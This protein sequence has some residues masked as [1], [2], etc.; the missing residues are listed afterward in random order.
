MT[1]PVH[2]HEQGV[3]KQRVIRA[4]LATSISVATL[5]HSAINHPPH[6]ADFLLVGI[7][8]PMLEQQQQQ[9]L[10]HE[11][12]FNT[13]SHKWRDAP[14]TVPAGDSALTHAGAA[15]AAAAISSTPSAAS[16]SAR[17]QIRR[18]QQDEKTG[19]GQRDL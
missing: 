11:I 9:C 19:R 15:A 18:Q 12:L 13:Y 7:H 4:P 17:L 2:K 5:I 3:Y 10:T 16:C 8:S 6:I 14:T 1:I